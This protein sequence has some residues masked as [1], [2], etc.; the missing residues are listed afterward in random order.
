M[1][2][3]SAEAGAAGTPAGTVIQ[4]RSRVI[5]TSRGGAVVDTAFSSVTNITVAQ[6]SAMNV[7]PASGAFTT[8]SDSTSVDYAV[9]AVNSGN[10]IDG[11]SFTAPSSRSFA[12]QVFRDGNGDGVL[13]S[14][15]RSLGSITQVTSIPADGSVSLILRVRIP[16][17]EALNGVKDSSRLIVRSKNDTTVANSGV[18]VTTV[19]TSGLNSVTPGLNVDVPAPLAGQ[20]VTYTYTLTN[21]GSVSATGLNIYDLLPAGVGFI[22]GSTTVG[23]FGGNTVPLQWTVGTLAPGQTVTITLTLQVNANVPTGTV[24]TNIFGIQYSVASNA[25]VLASNPSAV[26]VA[27]IQQYSVTV[28][29]YQSVQSRIAVDTVVHR[30]KVR[31]TGAF[32]DLFELSAVSSQRIPWTLY[33]DGNNN[34]VWD[35]AD[36]VFA[37]TNDS[38]SVDTDSLAAGDS[39]RVFARGI[40]PLFD[41]D[42]AVDTL[43]L[44]AVSAADHNKGASGKVQTS[45]ASPVV[46]MTKTMFP[47]GDQAA[48]AVVTYKITYENAGSV[49]VSNFAVIDSAP[50]HT[51][52]VRNSVK[53]NGIGVSDNSGNVSVATVNGNETVVTVSIGTLSANSNGSVE[54]KV[55][56]K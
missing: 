51:D 36:P 24:I 47:L 19:R 2:C 22:S 42:P 10:A 20:Q 33:K 49:A 48:G 13:Q 4:S 11:M 43:S 7:V 27:G 39:L 17:S 52:Y 3:L 32:K 23:T 6:R 8:A 40:L 50:L 21:N 44:T 9:I 5:F 18:Y 15:E 30:F 53:V 34:A 14:G 55:K 28:Q 56:I 45:I 41:I 46:T 26:T 16:R 38:A 54:F 12:T 31:N 29:P 35:A 25:Y 1:I 37:N